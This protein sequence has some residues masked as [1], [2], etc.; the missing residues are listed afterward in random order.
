MSTT[1]S[2]ILSL[3]LLFC[4]AFQVDVIVDIRPLE[5]AP[6]QRDVVLLLKCAKSVNW[7][8]KAHRVI[9]KLAVVVS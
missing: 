6:L 2:K 8:I 4:S 9:G 7:V 1:P 3:P 5:D